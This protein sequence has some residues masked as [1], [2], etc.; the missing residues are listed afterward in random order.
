MKIK[1]FLM[2]LI[3]VLM[4]V[5]VVAFGAVT[6]LKV[7]ATLASDLKFLVDGSVWSPKDVDG[8]A[9]TPLLYNGR[10]YV[11]ARAFLEDKGITVGYEKDTKTVQIDYQQLQALINLHQ[12]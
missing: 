5:S 9:L 11:P 8:S 7:Q 12:F 10:N 1:R 2:I 4:S 3:A 6:I